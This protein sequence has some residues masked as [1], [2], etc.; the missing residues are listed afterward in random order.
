[1]TCYRQALN[2][3][4]TPD[5]DEAFSAAAQAYAATPTGY[6]ATLDGIA[7][8]EAAGKIEAATVLEAAR[9]RGHQDYLAA[10]EASRLIQQETR[11]VEAVAWARN[12]PEHADAM[13]VYRDILASELGVDP[14]DLDLRIA[15][16]QYASANEPSLLTDGDTEAVRFLI[17]RTDG[18][19]VG[20][21]ADANTMRTMADLER[22]AA[23]ARREKRAR[24]ETVDPEGNRWVRYENQDTSDVL[25]S[26]NY[27]ENS[28][29]LVVS[30]FNRR[31][32]PSEQGPSY[33]YN[34]VNP[35]LFNALI[36]SRSMG[37][38]YSWVFSHYADGA[39]LNNAGPKDF[40]YSIHAANFM[41][42]TNGNYK[43]NAPT[44]YINALPYKP[45]S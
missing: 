24:F 45:R 23:H 28:G 35:A 29:T 7:A 42:P 3:D 4:Y 17:A 14:T 1:L 18:T 10:K 6:E 40:S 20:T 27:D 15:A 34:N 37:R 11:R 26:V 21:P 41:A 38:L 39:S 31:S 13:N 43:G 30:L 22:L 19:I 16:Q 8:L 33:T 5:V 12:V 2:G 9:A 32:A 44:S 25:Q 36:S